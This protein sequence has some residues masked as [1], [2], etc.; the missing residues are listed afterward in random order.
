[1]VEGNKVVKDLQME[2]KAIKNKTQMKGILE[3]KCLR[4]QKENTKDG[5]ESSGIKTQ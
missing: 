1:M 4:V 5:R 2:I 3:R